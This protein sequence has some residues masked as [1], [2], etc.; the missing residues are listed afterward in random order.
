MKIW[1]RS[2]A[3]K[4]LSFCILLSQASEAFSIEKYDSTCPCNCGLPE[5]YLNA[6]FIYWKPCTNNL[7]WAVFSEED[8]VAPS[9]PVGFGK[10]LFIDPNWEPGFRVKAGKDQLLCGVGLSTSYTYLKAEKNETKEAL[11]TQTL[12][13]TLVHGGL[14]PVENFP[15]NFAI[16]KWKQR[17]QT[18]DVLLSL[19]IECLQCHILTPYV[20]IEGMILHQSIS[21]EFIIGEIEDPD[22]SLSSRWESDFFGVGMKV[23]AFYNFQFNPCLSFF[24]DVSGSMIPGDADM[25]DNSFVNVDTAADSDLTFHYEDCLLL[26]GYRIALGLSFQ[27]KI[28]EMQMDI[29]GGYEF[30]RWHDIPNPRRY[31]QNDGGLALSTSPSTSTMGFHGVFLGTEIHF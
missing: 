3:F 27:M 11:Q 26:S 25:K 16:A 24:A 5:G 17:Y 22:E 9:N 10:Y 13:P 4:A 12:I 2:F 14:I 28:L 23:G 7:D 30:L 15:A 31:I 29:H 18:F 20:G 1:K 19:P 8:I 21:S 6:E